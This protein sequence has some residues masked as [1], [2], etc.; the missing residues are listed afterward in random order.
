MADQ[1]VG[2][3]AKITE[4]VEVAVKSPKSAFEMPPNVVV[5]PPTTEMALE[6]EIIPQSIGALSIA[7]SCRRKECRIIA[8]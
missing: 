3:A 6:S 7:K 4:R 5:D 1:D 8:S 2:T